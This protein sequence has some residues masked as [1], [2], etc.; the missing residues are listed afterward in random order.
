MV[1]SSMVYSTYGE[2]HFSLKCNETRYCLPASEYDYDSR[3]QK[4]VNDL[5]NADDLTIVPTQTDSFHVSKEK[6]IEDF[7]PH[8]YNCSSKSL[9]PAGT[10]AWDITSFNYNRTYVSS[11]PTVNSTASYTNIL[12]FYYNNTATDNDWPRNTGWRQC[13][14]LTDES[15]HEFD[16]TT[17]LMCMMSFEPFTLGF[18]FDNKT[19]EL[20]LSQR[21]TCDGIDNGHT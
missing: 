1:N 6:A 8:G 13:L 19:S 7:K 14:Y 10:Y 15:S 9:E 3:P 21:W 20:T 18:K 11:N 5:C 4:I 17:Q 2:A 12:E 16:G